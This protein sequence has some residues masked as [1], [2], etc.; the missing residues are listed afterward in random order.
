MVKVNYFNP[1]FVAPFICCSISNVIHIHAHVKI[2]QKDAKYF[3]FPQHLFLTL[4]RGVMLTDFKY[5]L[6]SLQILAQ[7]TVLHMTVRQQ[8][9]IT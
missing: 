7:P 3:N 9:L 8:D 4:F 5:L 6:S 2:W 1:P